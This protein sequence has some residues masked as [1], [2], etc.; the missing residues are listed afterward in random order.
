MK[1]T[2]Q[3]AADILG[4]IPNTVA[5]LIQ[6][7]KLHNVGDR[8]PKQRFTLDEKEVRAF[9]QVYRPRARRSEPYAIPTSPATSSGLVA[10]LARI[11]QKIDALVKV[12]S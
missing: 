7:G 6:Q 5:T 4:I 9:K 1:I 3:Q 11:E 2:A 8:A 10:T 12:W